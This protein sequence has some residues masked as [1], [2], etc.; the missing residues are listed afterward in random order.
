MS[1]AR[2]PRIT[3]PGFALHRVGAFVRTHPAPQ[4][5]AIEPSQ[6]PESAQ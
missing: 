4:S 1:L 5:S 2:I 6:I 3:H